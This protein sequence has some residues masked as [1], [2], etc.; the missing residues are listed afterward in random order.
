VPDS[1]HLAY[2]LGRLFSTGTIYHSYLVNVPPPTSTDSPTTTEIVF[3]GGISL[4]SNALNFSPVSSTDSENRQTFTLGFRRLTETRPYA[5]VDIF[6]I[7]VPSGYDGSYALSPR[8]ITNSTNAK[9][10]YGGSFFD[11]S[12]DGQWLAYNASNGNISAPYDIFKI[13]ADGSAKAVNLT[14]LK[15]NT[16]YVVS[17]WRK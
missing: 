17:G 15:T 12:P 2:N 10:F 13:K 8:R 6:T 9:N 4:N 16:A 11:W 3:S 5:R 1:Q 14:N 7:E